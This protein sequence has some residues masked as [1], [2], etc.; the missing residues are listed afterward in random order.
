MDITIFN[1]RL[2]ETISW[3]LTQELICDPVEDDAVVRRRMLNR[4]GVELFSKGYRMAASYEHAGWVLRLIAKTRIRNAAKTQDEGKRLMREAD[5]GSII[6]PLRQQLRSE[7]LR[8][9]AHSLAH[10][11]ADRSAIVNQVTEARS[12]IL[13]ESGK[14]LELHSSG[15]HGGRLLVYAPEDN[16]ACGA[17]EYTSLGFFDVDNVPPWDTW[18]LMRGKYLI[19]WVPPQLIRL[20]QE[21]LNVNP[22]Q[23]I[24]W[25]NDP[26]LSKERISETLGEF[27]AKVA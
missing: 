21:G 7:T 14:H 26:S 13:R 3:C 23:C 19:S 9:F 5:V 20:V 11:G 8:P 15:L 17:A 2:N 1:Q 10:S 12:R 22:E 18:I 4:Q 27:S 6:P 25:A 16:L 24:L